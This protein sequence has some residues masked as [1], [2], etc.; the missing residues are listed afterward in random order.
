MTI[1]RALVSVTFPARFV[2]I[3]AMN[4]CPCGY[5]GDARRA[6]KCMPMAV[7]KYIGR[8][9][10]PLLDRIDLHIEV[11]S[12]AF[13]DLASKIEGTTSQAMRDQV[14][15]ARACQRARFGNGEMLNGRM[16]PRL[17]RKHCVLD[18]ESMALMKEA[19]E[20]LGLSAR[21]HDRILRV[22]RTIADLEGRPTPETGH[23]VE[24]IGYRTLDRKL[25]N[26]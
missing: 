13:T 11:P 14:L 8:I 4:A 17:L 15:Q 3:A 10:G 22:A 16:T 9:S 19:M 25:W 6:C 20:S 23:V 21:A 24:A 26:R 12:V 7:D 5:M 18:A 1:S 2:L